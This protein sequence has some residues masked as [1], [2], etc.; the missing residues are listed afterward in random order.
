MLQ[1]VQEQQG[2]PLSIRAFAEA[3]ETSPRRIRRLIRQG[4]LRTIENHAGEV[5]LP[6]S[7]LTRLG[8]WKTRRALRQSM[9]VSIETSY[10]G[11]PAVRDDAV[12]ETYAMQIPLSRHEA[13]MMRVGY[14]ESEL[15]VCKRLLEEGREREDLLREEFNGERERAE[16]AETRLEETQDKLVET[17]LRLEEMR[18]QVIESSFQA[19]Q[20]QEEVKGLRERLMTPW[21]SRALEILRSKKQ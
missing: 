19:V 4:R 12:A 9:E 2:R 3:S 15:A 6:E 18:A 20:L 5:R 14:L 21:W 10:G 7:E 17:E 8:S 13:A 1:A 16:L 11:L